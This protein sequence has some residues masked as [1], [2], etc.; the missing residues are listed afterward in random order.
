MKTILVLHGVNLNMF[1]K[2]DPGQYGTTTLDK[3]D[4]KQKEF[5]SA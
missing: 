5:V 4:Q 1:G 2:M 3:I